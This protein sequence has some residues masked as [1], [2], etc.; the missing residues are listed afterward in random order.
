MIKI[1]DFAEIAQVAT[2]TLRYY[3]E[4]GLFKPVYVD[5]DTGYRFYAIE[6][7]LRLNRILALKDLGLELGQIVQLLDEEVSIEALQGMLRLKQ[8][9]LQQHIQD[10]QEQLVRIEARLRYIAQEGHRLA[11]EVVL[12][13]V[14]PLTV[15]A[16]YTHVAGFLPNRQYA[17]ALLAM[18]KQ[19]AICPAGPVLYIYHEGTSETIDFNVEVAVPVEPGSVNLAKLSP[20]WNRRVVLRELP[21]VSIM[22]SLIHH[23]NP[24]GSVEAYQ[25]LGVWIQTNG[26]TVTGP[27]RKLSLRWSGELDD[28]LT[29]IQYPIEMKR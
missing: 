17:N 6:Q 11:R 27:C 25:A 29:E 24:H 26:Y 14:K 10:E 13:E 22:A 12:K 3:D 2:S 8:A 19:N 4:I 7:L 20:D 23:G 21:A 15:I 1:R 28:Y 5:P 18:L 9:R 16:G